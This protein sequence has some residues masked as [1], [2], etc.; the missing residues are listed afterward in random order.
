MC[1]YFHRAYPETEKG[2][3]NVELLT[4]NKRQNEKENGKYERSRK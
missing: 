4:L 3:L 2:I 1:N